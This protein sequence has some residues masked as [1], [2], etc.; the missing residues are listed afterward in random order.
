MAKSTN[1]ERNPRKLPA[2]MKRLVRAAGWYSLEWAIAVR[3]I[4]LADSDLRQLYK[5]A[6]KIED[7]TEALDYAMSMKK[8]DR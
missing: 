1:P 8:G 2:E 5:K 4:R 7:A 6:R 3:L